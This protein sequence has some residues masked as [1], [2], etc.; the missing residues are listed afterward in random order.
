MPH[1]HTWRTARYTLLGLPCDGYADRVVQFA[2]ATCTA[3]VTYTGEL[4][5]SE[6]L[7]D[8]A[9]WDAQMALDLRR[10][11]PEAHAAQ[12]GM[13]RMVRPC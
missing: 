1:T 12:R 10:Q 6:P 13:E 5:M 8:P 7:H 2:C 9:W 4:R 11:T 3:F